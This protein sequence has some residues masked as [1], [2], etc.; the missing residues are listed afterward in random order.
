MT[1]ADIGFVRND[2]DAVNVFFVEL[3]NIVHDSQCM[4][5]AARTVSGHVENEFLQ[6]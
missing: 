1:Q 6:S 4:S 3:T 2:E 5:L